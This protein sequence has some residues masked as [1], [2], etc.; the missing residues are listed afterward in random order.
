[1]GSRNGPRNPCLSILACGFFLMLLLLQP[2][3]GTEPLGARPGK[4]GLLVKRQRLDRTP[5]SHTTNTTPPL[6]NSSSH[7]SLK[8]DENNTTAST[9]QST[10]P[11]ETS[12]SLLSWTEPA[13]SCKR[14]IVPSHCPPSP[15]QSSLS[16]ATR[17]F[18]SRSSTT[19]TATST[20][21]TAH[22]ALTICTTPEHRPHDR[23]LLLSHIFFP[24]R[25]S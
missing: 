9:T 3:A 16:L 5:S 4:I 8:R 13:S 11:S 19:A 12:S 15:K 1:M 24:P 17:P 18:L 25:P 21:D 23:Q 14:T 10:L 22:S 6:H 7:P 2:A 20:R